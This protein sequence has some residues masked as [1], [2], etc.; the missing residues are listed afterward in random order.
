MVIPKRG[1]VFA[2]LQAIA[3]GDAGQTQRRRP[4]KG[5][6]GAHARSVGEMAASRITLTLI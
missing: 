3:S 6:K 4:K 1:L 5:V 2:P